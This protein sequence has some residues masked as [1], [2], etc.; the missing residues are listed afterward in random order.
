M[1]PS[2]QIYLDDLNSSIACCRSAS[3]LLPTTLTNKECGANDVLCKLRQWKWI[4]ESVLIRPWVATPTASSNVV[5][6]LPTE[7]E[8][9]FLQSK[10]ALLATTSSPPSSSLSLSLRERAIKYHIDSKS[11]IVPLTDEGTA[12]ILRVLF[13]MP[14]AQDR[15]RQD[16]SHSSSTTNIPLSDDDH[17]AKAILIQ[18]WVSS[19]GILIVHNCDGNQVVS[20][21]KEVDSFPTPQPQPS[22]TST[23]VT[24][25]KDSKCSTNVNKQF[26]FVDLFA[27]IGGFRIALEALGGRCIG[28]CEIDAYARDTYRRNFHIG[29][30][31]F[32]VNDIA[33]LE[34]P[35]GYADVICGGFPCQSFST[36]ANFPS[37]RVK[38]NIDDE[39]NANARKLNSKYHRGRQGGLDTPN[40]GKLFFHLPRILRKARP[41]LFI[42]ENVKGLL[43]VDN[44]TH[45]QTILHLLEES[46]YHVSHGIIDTSLFLPQRRERI[47]FVGIRLDLMNS[48]GFESQLS[49]LRMNTLER[50]WKTKYQIYGN[51]IIDAATMDKFD[52]MLLRSGHHPRRVRSTPHT[53]LP[54]CLG[55]ILEC[56][57]TVIKHHSHCFLTPLQWQK[58]CTQTYLQFHSDG[59]GQLLTK[60]D[61]CCQTLVSS[62][63]QSYLMHSQFVVP[64]DS[65]YLLATKERLLAAAL[66]NN[67]GRREI[68]QNTA[69]VRKFKDTTMPRFFT[70]REWLVL[71]CI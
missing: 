12:F 16:Y 25:D 1:S 3:L 67:D 51:D 48:N 45:F 53:V 13:D 61:A 58:V 46:G 37:N 22:T 5:N 10:Y 7:A 68:D 71:L 2:F 23:P 60:D 54:S 57:E 28:S 39:C 52:R 26:T 36:M 38:A 65:I 24:D 4:S 40:R 9:L 21:S 35:P 50:E 55:D 59:T 30:D 64:R 8:L 11:L 42:F 32:Y 63:R 29:A 41:K 31:E 44:G 66:K 17:E 14:M 27:G 15:N 47:Y 19:N 49:S 34:V 69:L 18:S 20:L 6:C 62:Y 33:R 70:P 43:N 56:S